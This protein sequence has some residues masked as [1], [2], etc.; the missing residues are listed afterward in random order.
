MRIK[1]LAA[2]AA[3]LGAVALIPSAAQAQAPPETQCITAPSLICWPQN[4]PITRSTFTQLGF[5]KYLTTTPTLYRD[6]SLYVDSYG[7]NDNWFTGSRPN[8]FIVVLDNRGKQIWVSQLFQNA[9]LCGVMDP[10]CSSRR[11]EVHY[12][13]LP[14]EVAQ[15]AADLKIYQ[16]DSPSF[17]ATR[18]WVKTT[19]AT[20]NDLLPIIKAIIA[21]L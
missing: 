8:Q 6:G 10:S 19:I 3:A 12:Q 18:D 13:H 1:T 15:Y 21:L 17:A 5:G 4:G 9:T 16:S 20:A 14:E 2:V 7:V 11:R